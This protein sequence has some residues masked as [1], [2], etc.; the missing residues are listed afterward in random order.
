MFHSRDPQ[1]KKILHPLDRI[2]SGTSLRF[3]AESSAVFAAY[4]LA[5]RIGL[6]IPFTNGNVSPVWPAAGVALVSLLLLGFRV[7]PAIAAGAFLVNFLSPI[8]H[9]AAF[10]IALG[11]TA[12]PLAGAWLLQRHAGFSTSLAR[13]RDVIGLIA[14]GAL[15]GTAISA[16]IGTCVLFLT[17]VHSW[18]GF[19]SAWLIWWLGDTMGV[20]IV[21]PIVLTFGRIFRVCRSRRIPEAAG[22][23]S[24]TL[25]T[26]FLIFESHLVP[27]AAQD[28]LA[29]GAFPFVIWA[30]IRFETAGAALIGGLIAT[31]AIWETARGL[32]PFVQDSS[33]QNAALLQSYIAAVSVT[34]MALAAVVTERAELIR[35]KMESEALRKAEERYR[36]IAATAN[37]GIWMLD[38]HL[39]TCFVNRRMAE[40]L[41]Y[42]IDEMLGASISKF[43]FEDDVEQKKASLA[44][45]K[46]G[47]SEPLEDRLR[48]KDGS[49]LWARM[50]TSGSFGAD[51]EF[52]GALA[53]VSDITDQ[54]RRDAERQNAME[55]VT[56]LS[57]AVKQ[58]AD[59]V[60]ITDKQ[61]II[62]YVNPAFEVTT[63]YTRKEV[64]GKTPRILKS[65]QHD[66]SFYK[67]LWDRLLTG[68][69]FRGTLVNRKKC[70]ELYW[71]EQTITP[72]TDT[73]GNITHFVSVLKDITELRAKQEQEVQLRLAR[74]VQQRFYTAT[75]SVPGFDVAAAA[76]PASETGGDYFDFIPVAEGDFYIAIGDAS[77]HGFGSAL[78]MALTR[79][80]V[81]SFAAMKLDVAEVLAR[82]NQMLA[83]DLEDNRYV[84]LLLARIDPGDRSLTYAS[85]GHV[86]GFLL[87]GEGEVASFLTSTGPP[88]GLFSCP[89][90]A[91]VTTALTPR[92]IITLVTD[93]VLETTTVD[94][95]QFGAE[96]V[97]Q[98][99]H[100]HRQ[101]PAR[102]IAEG[103]FAAARAFGGS[104]PQVDDVTSVVVKVGDLGRPGL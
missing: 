56:L 50:S 86:P 89:E 102:T 92:Q 48:R 8:P 25:L 58:T 85:A 83:A 40:M 63:G 54:R 4:F 24:G 33:F 100:S 87:N 21:V 16:T 26:C 49:E 93:G 70:G 17:H 76:Y 2:H 15:G 65:G 97:I 34:G 39:I 68:Q 1:T 6:N 88:V 5:G 78:V 55:K 91:R 90:F 37:E 45:R 103:I 69:T 46:S 104:E 28:V 43:V 52:E 59:S 31:A 99:L 57:R 94:G 23:L 61:G 10:G 71:A 12:G 35:Q 9:A 66:S 80:Y 29:Y 42:S 13:F 51:G 18:S 22:L 81:R 84:T 32:G 73:S 60:V 47:V 62:L 41:G 3:L 95:N 101:N 19:G 74:E 75:I 98:Y 36:E 14:F 7:W 64:L 79:A 72:I 11:N 82:V 30:A 44:Q 96:R 53:M 27:G 77:G 38:A 67:G 20:L